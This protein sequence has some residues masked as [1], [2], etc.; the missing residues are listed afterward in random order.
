MTQQ[1]SRSIALPK[2]LTMGRLRY[3]SALS[4]LLVSNAFLWSRVSAQGT[5][6]LGGQVTTL[7]DVQKFADLS[8]DVAEIQKFVDNE[9]KDRAET[10]FN[11][12][13]HA[14]D[15]SGL[16]FSLA[17]L[18]DTLANASP[19]TPAF[20]YH[21]YGLTDRSTNF[22]FELEAQTGYIN[23]F[24]TDIFEE[25]LTFSIDAII[26]V[27]MWMY[28]THLLYDGVY[29]CHERTV[30]NRA[31]AVELGG[32]GFDEFI[33]LWIGDGQSPGVANGDVLYAWAQFFGDIFGMNSPQA[34]TNEIILDLYGR[35]KSALSVENACSSDVPGTAAELWKVATQIVSEMSKPLFQ[36]LIY[37]ILTGD[38]DGV[39]IYSFALVPQ[40]AKCRPSTYKRL[41]QRLL[42][43]AF[44]FDEESVSM[45]LEDLQDAYA[46]F[47][48]TCDA[49]GEIEGDARLECDQEKRNPPLAGYR[50][51]TDVSA[52]S[53]CG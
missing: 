34:P 16:L 36:G 15:D 19:K 5:S 42:D 41:K 14:A 23:K 22:A 12:G 21:L 33:A 17:S 27:S 18:G 39:R 24:I 8:Q 6:L 3:P 49:I 38:E 2:I 1:P 26:T 28:A 30:A 35:A 48:Y 51:T 25:S 50:P 9:S 53:V 20:L 40:I 4:I 32:A 45:V 37:S 10:L 11:Q 44:D 52:V 47:G 29:R 7:T 31:N 13:Q 43:D 46:C